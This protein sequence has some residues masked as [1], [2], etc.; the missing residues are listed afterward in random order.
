MCS[1]KLKTP[2]R[3]PGVHPDHVFAS[4]SLTKM[5]T[6]RQPR[7]LAY[8]LLAYA[9][10]I[11]DLAPL[12]GFVENVCQKHASLAIRP[13]QYEVVGKYLI[14]TMQDMLGDAFTPELKAAWG[15]A[16]W[17][18]ADMMIGREKELYEQDPSW[19]DWRDFK[20]VKKE[21]E[22]S[23]ITSFYL[24]PVDGKLLPLFEPGQY[25]SIRIVVDQ[26]TGMKQPRQ[27][28][29]SSRPD[30]TTYRISVRRAEAA[31]GAEQVSYPN[32]ISNM[33]HDRY[34]VG[35]VVELTHPRGE[36]YVQGETGAPAAPLVLL[37][38]G[39]G[40]TPL[41]SM[42]SEQAVAAPER[43]VVL[44]HGASSTVQRAFA[45]EVR[46]L[47]VGS[48][49]RRYVSFVTH[50]SDASGVA[51]K[52]YDFLGR[53]DVSLL[54][55]E[56]DLHLSNPRT[57]YYVCGPPGFMDAVSAELQGKFGVPAEHIHSELFTEVK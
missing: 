53:V 15:K 51:G 23:E 12:A 22:S 57:E 30:K 40:I 2:A 17:Q 31:D 36:F 8:S 37:G 46:A 24:E 13:E 28:S 4:H 50:A 27:Y 10:N 48:P 26:V 56:K 1:G 35:D 54:D 21:R 9:Q 5:E 7:A 3:F 29:L 25:T 42:F 38:A 19:T 43:P 52:D 34:Q 11:D 55:A 49:V 6:M 18:L 47:T 32:L 44:V 33:L 41:L 14:M 45:G 39:V 20:I 16:Y